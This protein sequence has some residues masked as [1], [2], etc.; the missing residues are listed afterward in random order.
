MPL[1]SIVPEHLERCRRYSVIQHATLASELFFGM[2]IRDQAKLTYPS[3]HRQAWRRSRSAR[4]SEASS[5]HGRR[6]SKSPDLEFRDPPP[7][8]NSKLVFIFNC[9]SALMC[10][11][12]LILAK[13]PV[14][15][16]T[17]RKGMQPL[18]NARVAAL[19]RVISN[20]R[21]KKD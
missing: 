21:S 2:R 13:S 7:P 17:F 3:R 18:H 19:E 16:N 14:L 11:L 5:A 8:I 15:L 6:R 9:L 10:S 12:S 1:K 4:P 20:R